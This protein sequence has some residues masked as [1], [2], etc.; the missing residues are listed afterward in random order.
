MALTIPM[1]AVVVLGILASVSWIALAC[2]LV[3]RPALKSSEILGALED[4][5]QSQRLLHTAIERLMSDRKEM[6]SS[7]TMPRAHRFDRAERSAVT[8]P[9]LISVPNLA[10]TSPSVSSLANE[11][12]AQRFGSIWSLADAGL[13]PQAVATQTGHPIGQV[14]LILG[15]RRQ[16]NSGAAS[17]YVAGSGSRD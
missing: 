13:S 12:L 17:I 1:V 5:R 16:H 10:A 14:E 2:V 15:L 9:T 3:R 6:P 4:V 8:G 7:S 11:E